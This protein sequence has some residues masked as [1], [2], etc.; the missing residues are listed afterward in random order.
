MS[1]V[2]DSLTVVGDVTAVDLTLSG[3]LYGAT[4][5]SFTGNVLAGGDVRGVDVNASGCITGVNEALTGDLTV[6]DMNASGCVTGVNAVL[7]G[8]LGA[9]DVN[10]SGCVTGVN[11]VLTGD[12][13]AVDVNASGCVTG[14]NGA[15]TGPISASSGG[16]TNNF[17]VGGSSLHTGVASFA[18]DVEVTG[19]AYA[20]TFA[21]NALSSDAI[22]T[23]VAASYA[24]GATNY[25]WPGSL[26]I[27]T[28]VSGAAGS[29][30]GNGCWYLNTSA[31]GATGSS[32]SGPVTLFAA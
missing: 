12:L 21:I 3:S 2:P 14:V 9:V 16:I 15:F 8:D 6:V 17:S 4:S 1:Q 18:D 7:T 13:G 23:I 24:P 27:A 20:P 29:T 22:P 26:W 30:V 31:S 25:A 11:A 19:C 5:G 28:A 32:W 10:A